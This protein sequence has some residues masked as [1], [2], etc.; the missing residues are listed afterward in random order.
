MGKKFRMVLAV[1]LSIVLVYSAARIVMTEIE[2]KKAEDIYEK[3]QNEYF[4]FLDKTAPLWQEADNLSSEEYFPDVYVDF[5]AL[6]TANP[7]IAGW[8][9]I[10]DSSVNFPLLRAED[11]RKY[12]SLSYD[13][14]H[15][16]SGSI[17]I[18]YRNSPDFSDDNTVIYGHNMNNGSMFGSLKKYSDAEYMDEHRNLYIF[19]GERIF[20]YRVFS[21]YKTES[22]SRSYTLSFPDNT[23]FFDYIDYAVTH[24]GYRMDFAPESKTPLLTLSTCTSGG[25]SKRFVVHAE[26]ISV[27]EY[28]KALPAS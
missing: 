14:Q 9:W 1:I 10:P 17:F 8:I 25:Q 16:D 22:G 3:S 15:T 28:D 19:T 21:A 18:D 2:Y 6:R 11:N 26:L 5:K 27:K 7:E 20:K 24:S 12:L 13:M 4:H 23:C